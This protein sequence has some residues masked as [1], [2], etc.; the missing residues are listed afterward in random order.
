[1]GILPG[2]VMRHFL[3][4]LQSI[5]DLVKNVEVSFGRKNSE[6]LIRIPVTSEFF[7]ALDRARDQCR[8]I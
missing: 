8:E 4:A 6:R 2:A 5:A 1:M 3:S 7:V